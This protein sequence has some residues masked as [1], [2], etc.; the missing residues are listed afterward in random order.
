MRIGIKHIALLVVALITQ[1]CESKP[2]VDESGNKA[3]YLNGKLHR[4]DSPTLVFADD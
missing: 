3:W 1:G 2:V 4:E